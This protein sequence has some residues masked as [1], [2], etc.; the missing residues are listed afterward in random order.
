MSPELSTSCQAHTESLTLIPCSLGHHTEHP[1]WLKLVGSNPTSGSPP[2]K[3]TQSSHQLAKREGTLSHRRS[4]LK[5]VLIVLWPSHR[6]CQ[7]DQLEGANH[8]KLKQLQFRLSQSVSV[9]SHS[10]SLFKLLLQLLL[11]HTNLKLLIQ[12]PLAI[13]NTPFHYSTLTRAVPA[14]PSHFRYTRRSLRSQF[15]KVSIRSFQAINILMF[16]KHQKCL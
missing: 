6:T 12:L 8:S 16:L 11:Y 14:S 10:S 1:K 15:R 3:V 7:V 13:T 5:T 9:S 2:G 4:L